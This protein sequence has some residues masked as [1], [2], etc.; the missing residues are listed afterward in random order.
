MGSNPTPAVKKTCRSRDL[1]GPELCSAKTWTRSPAVSANHLQ[2]P[3]SNVCRTCMG[4]GVCSDQDRSSSTAASR[5][6]TTVSFLRDFQ[7][8]SHQSGDVARPSL[9]LEGGDTARSS[10]CRA[11]RLHSCRRARGW[12]RGCGSTPMRHAFMSRMMHR[13]ISS[14]VRHGSWV[15]SRARSRSA[16]TSTCRRLVRSDSCSLVQ[17]SSGPPEIPA[18]ALDLILK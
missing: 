4:A 1:R 18:V 9:A 14:T 10:Q 11:A 13:G 17:G 12:S 5:P 8:A 15:T 6:P 3:S 16:A 7:M 2:T